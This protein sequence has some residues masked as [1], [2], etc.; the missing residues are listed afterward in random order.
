MNRIQRSRGQLRLVRRMS[1]RELAHQ[2][3]AAYR[4][5]RA[6]RGLL[7]PHSMLCDETTIVD[8]VTRRFADGAPGSG[9]HL[10]AH[11]ARVLLAVLHERRVAA[12]TALRERHGELRAALFSIRDLAGLV[13]DDDAVEPR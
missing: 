4:R 7:M 1:V 13:L 9:L 12:T 6:V 8:V 3:I 2:A 11:E 5:R 10:D